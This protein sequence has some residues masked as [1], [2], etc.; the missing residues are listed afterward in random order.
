M[1]S[2]SRTIYRIR[3][4]CEGVRAGAK[5]TATRAPWYR[6]FV[7]VVFYFLRYDRSINKHYVLCHVLASLI[8][9]LAVSSITCFG[10]ESLAPFIVV[11]SLI[12]TIGS[13]TLIDVQLYLHQGQVRWLPT[14]ATLPW[15]DKRLVQAYLCTLLERSL[16]FTLTSLSIGIGYCVVNEQLRSMHNATACLFATIATTALMLA[17]A[18]L[19]ST[20]RRTDVRYRIYFY[21]KW[22]R[23]LAVC[24]LIGCVV[25]VRYDWM[26]PPEWIS[27]LSLLR[28]LPP[29]WPWAVVQ[30]GMEHGFGVGTCF[31]WIGLALCVV[32]A[33]TTGLRRL[34]ER[35]SILE[36]VGHDNRYL[37]GLLKDPLLSP[38]HFVSLL[39]QE[40]PAE[41]K[42]NLDG[43]VAQAIQASTL[44]ILDFG[45][46]RDCFWER[47][48]W[49]SPIL[50]RILSNAEKAVVSA[51]Y[52]HRGISS[53][54]D[55]I[56]TT[57]ACSLLGTAVAL[58]IDTVGSMFAI[59]NYSLFAL[60]YGI[61]YVV[62]LASR[63]IVNMNFFLLRS[64]P[65]SARDM[66][67]G[68]W[69]FTCISWMLMLFVAAPFWAF[70]LAYLGWQLD[71]IFQGL[72][73]VLIL[74]PCV[75]L[76]SH[77]ISLFVGTKQRFEALD[78][79]LILTTIVFFGVLSIG[80]VLGMGTVRYAL[81][82]IAIC[83]LVWPLTYIIY[84]WSISRFHHRTLDVG[85]PWN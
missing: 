31:L 78:F 80:I 46:Y 60:F 27:S 84:R 55:T 66:V 59:G 25:S 17:T 14:Y 30:W 85:S 61:Y 74:L 8:T 7:Y 24:A 47:Q 26:L 10:D 15:G 2:S 19:F 29:C 33:W 70:S 67:G 28:F 45:R 65:F 53:P 57:L 56:K 11:Q 63:C 22:L 52:A 41:P 37:H 6:K 34:P 72:V 73:I 44:P 3:Q 18:I 48:R 75:A 49:L 38:E 40:G 62:M 69:K 16:L 76:W 1:L 50:D 71:A 42:G 51:V 4:S 13:I 21:L 83:M 5:S 43:L 36:F 32:F 9:A 77:L 35:L 79:S 81:S 58:M 68:A 54:K 12:A 82:R 23:F 20:I 64:L 39:D